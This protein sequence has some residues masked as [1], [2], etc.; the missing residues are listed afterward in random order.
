[1][2]RKHIGQRSTAAYVEV[3]SVDV[4][5]LLMADSQV[6]AW[7]V[8]VTWTKFTESKVSTMVKQTRSFSM[9]RVYLCTY[10]L[11]ALSFEL[12]IV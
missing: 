3:D 7:S 11:K 1:M 6:Q 10:L 4:A 12:F 9:F 8:G 5:R 2:Y